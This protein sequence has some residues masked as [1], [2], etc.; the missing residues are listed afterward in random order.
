LSEELCRGCERF[1]TYFYDCPPYQSPS[2]TED[3]RRRK[4][5]ADKFYYN[6]RNHKRFEVRLGR[7]QKTGYDPPMFTQKGVDVLLSVDLVRLAWSGK[8]N[9]AVLVTGDSDFVPAVRDVKDAGIIVELW[10]SRCM[11]MSDELFQV[12]DDRFP[13]SRDLIDKCRR[14]GN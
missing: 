10:F 8:I 9:K 6:L 7:L 5:G 11:H 1:R 12:C 14:A 2:P 4:S 3:E 13:L